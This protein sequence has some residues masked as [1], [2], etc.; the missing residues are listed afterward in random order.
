MSN[1]DLAAATGTRARTATGATALADAVART[2]CTHVFALMGDGNMHLLLALEERGVGVV[3]V[4]HE[5]AAVAMAEGYTWSAGR[6]GICSVTHG[7]GLTHVA[8]SLVV[9]ARNR[10]PLVVIAAETPAGYQGA[11]RFDQASFA[12][13]CEAV[14]RTMGRDDD[15]EEALTAALAVARNRS[16]PVVLGIAADLL[17]APAA[18][19]AT[20]GPAVFPAPSGAPSA[21]DDAVA[22]DRLARLL[23]DAE[24]PVLLAGR[25]AA[26]GH[27]PDLLRSLAD[28]FGAGLATT[29]PAKGMFDGHPLDLG[30]AGGLAHP[31]AERL[32]GS[33]DLVVAFGASMGRS[34]TQSRRLFARAHVVRVVDEVPG[35]SSA[36]AP[37]GGGRTETLRGN[38]AGTLRRTVSLTRALSG[39][40][41]PWFGPVGPAADCWREDLRDFA[42][43]VA[44]GTVDPRRAVAGISERLPEDATVVISNGHCSGFAAAFVTVPARGR[45]FA[46]QGFGSIGQALT[47]A[48]GVA[49]GTPDRKT[50]VF[51]GDAAFMM[52]IQELDT[53]ARA[54]ADLTVF[55]LN[56]QALG[57]E[58]QRLHRDGDNAGA[59]VVPPPAIAPLAAAFG[60]RSA[61][62]DAAGAGEILKEA[63]RPGLAV[64]DVR[65][66]RS[67]LSRHMRLPHTL[68]GQNDG[69][70][71]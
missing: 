68:T 6:T 36:G 26:D 70:G 23:T 63:L 3:E 46:A 61:T 9:A 62:L 52:H 66:A 15:P 2:G 13:S 27:S 50:V 39:A 11:Q 30:I 59:A 60:A 14:Y 69:A 1:T 17:T 4:R 49:L 57:T 40:R 45:F 38:A 34:T 37:G 8:T 32:L 18:E 64:V 47:T 56:D 10:T 24:R 35:G 20:R 19:R 65:T 31:A 28:H 58:Y 22:A 71:Q 51:E 44:D 41:R 33:A 55:V 67:V 48:I 25:G 16:R 53:A 12:A 42:P 21:E 54:G 29:L 5:S 43:P 7:P